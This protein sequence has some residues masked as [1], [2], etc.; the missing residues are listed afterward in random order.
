M[1]P[2]E[3]HDISDPNSLLRITHTPSQR[4]ISTRGQDNG[5]LFENSLFDTFTPDGGLFI[6]EKIPV[7]ALEEWQGWS[8]L[9]FQDI[10]FELLSIFISPFEIPH[11]DLRIIARRSF[12]AEDSVVPPL[13]RLSDGLYLL[14]LFHGPKGLP[15]DMELRL[16]GNLFEYFLERRNAGKEGKDRH[17]I[18]I[19]DPADEPAIAL[20][21]GDRR[22]M[23]VIRLQSDDQQE[24]PT[25]KAGLAALSNNIHTLVV[26]G[27]GGDCED[28]IDMLFAMTSRSL[29]PHLNLATASP[30]NWARTL[31]QMVIWIHGF[32]ALKRVLPSFDMEADK[33]RLVLPTRT[34]DIIACFLV[35]RMGL[36]IDKIV[37]ATCDRDPLVS[38]W[39]TCRYR[40]QVRV[41]DLPA[42][43]GDPSTQEGG[44]SRQQP[45]NSRRGD[46]LVTSSFERLLWY[47]A[48]EFVSYAH[49]G[50]AWNDKEAGVEVTK[51]LRDLIDRDAFGPVYRDITRIGCNNFV[52]EPVAFQESNSSH[53]GADAASGRADTESLPTDF[54]WD[55][56][57]ATAAGVVASQRS[58]SR[59]GIDV[60]HISLAPM[61]YRK[62]RNR[63]WTGDRRMSVSA[64][65]DSPKGKEPIRSIANDWQAVRAA[66]A[67][68]VERDS[69][70]AAE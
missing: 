34:F 24:D 28:I 8:R 42:L 1:P 56:C 29:E 3:P 45:P 7:L 11:D 17:H 61:A 2:F 49:M 43:P 46:I 41:G 66:I 52:A 37:I 32:F 70:R 64:I 63:G 20:A 47:L 5:L 10:A 14:E 65:R 30:I 9:C 62:T 68:L 18:A 21:L 22:D 38:F 59:T 19:L 58:L 25:E 39:A 36:P 55:A 13:V 26:K 16:I 27:S 50:D 33:V 40:R 48:R 15:E 67:E 31:S 6:P 54:R 57:E 60:P 53:R 35:R 23:S 44:Q 4:Y 51:W 69:M 12:G